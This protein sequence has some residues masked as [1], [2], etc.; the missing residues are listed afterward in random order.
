MAA[1][2][3]QRHERAGPRADADGHP[4]RLA[5][6]TARR[7]RRPGASI[8]RWSRSRPTTGCG[9][10]ASIRRS[11]RFPE[12]R[13]VSRPAHHSTRPERYRRRHCSRLRPP[14]SIWRRHCWRC[15][16]PRTRQPGCTASPSGSGLERTRLFLLASAYGGA[17]GSL[18]GGRFYMHQTL[19][20]GGLCQRPLRVRRRRPRR[21]RPIR[22]SRSSSKDSKSQ[23][24]PARPDH[25]PADRPLAV[26]D[27]PLARAR[28]AHDTSWHPNA[29][30]WMGST[31]CPGGSTRAPR[32]Y[33]CIGAMHPK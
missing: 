29:L 19:S 27:P 25:T 17:D 28:A 32:H 18:E 9:R 14:T 15:S 16:A 6:R 33:M 3:A 20:G 23:R 7:L 2:A 21:G 26:C 10:G 11:G 5:R 13:D 24:G 4:G 22:S 12:R 31:H 1:N 30:L 8:A